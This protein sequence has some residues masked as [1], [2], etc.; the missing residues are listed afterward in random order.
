MFYS[1]API[2][3]IE[4]LRPVMVFADFGPHSFELLSEPRVAFF[5]F[6]H[7]LPNTFELTICSEDHFLW[8]TKA[9]S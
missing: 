8:G 3:Y 7:L 5:G 4:A 6:L 1:V 9:D 2:S